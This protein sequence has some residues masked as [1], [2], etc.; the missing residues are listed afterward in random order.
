MTQ[1][2]VRLSDVLIPFVPTHLRSMN[3]KCSTTICLGYRGRLSGAL[4]GLKTSGTK[5]AQNRTIARRIE[6]I[7]FSKGEPMSGEEDEGKR[8]KLG[9][10]Q[11]MSS[12]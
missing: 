3:W 2:M 5:M 4:Q 11:D 12:V 10:R 7:V 6:D 8:S 9:L 1:R